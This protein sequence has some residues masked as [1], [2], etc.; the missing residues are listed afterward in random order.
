MSLQHTSIHDSKSR[1]KWRRLRRMLC[2]ALSKRLRER[3]DDFCGIEIGEVLSN[4]FVVAKKGGL[5]QL[6]EVSSQHLSLCKNK[7]EAYGAR[8]RRHEG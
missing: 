5:S 4:V 2:E 8:F 3:N 7:F 1:T 6:H